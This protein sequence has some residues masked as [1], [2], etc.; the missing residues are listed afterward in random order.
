MAALEGKLEAKETD[1]GSVQDA[2]W[3]HIQQR[4]DQLELNCNANIGEAIAAGIEEMQEAELA[5]GGCF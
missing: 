1:T 4:L 5:A 2:L 3:K